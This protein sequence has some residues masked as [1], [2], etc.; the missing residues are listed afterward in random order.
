MMPEMM[1]QAIGFD[2]AVE[3]EIWA[4]APSFACN[5]L[6]NHGDINTLAFEFDACRFETLSQERIIEFYGMA[7]QDAVEKMDDFGG[8]L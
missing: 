1:L 5:P 8:N 4:F 3:G 7:D 6:L 2:H